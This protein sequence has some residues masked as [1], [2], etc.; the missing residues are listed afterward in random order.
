MQSDV[1]GL[2]RVLDEIG[3]GASMFLNGVSGVP[4]SQYTAEQAASDLARL[5]VLA[6]E[7]ERLATTSS[8]AHL[9]ICPQ[10]GDASSLASPTGNLYTASYSTASAIDVLTEQNIAMMKAD[11]V[12]REGIRRVATGSYDKIDAL[13]KQKKSGPT[14]PPKS[15]PVS[16]APSS[17]MTS[18]QPS[19]S[20]FAAP[21]QQ[22]R[23]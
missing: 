23:M 12:M 19:S 15:G 7:C 18:T 20:P 14:F 9:E 16:S 5:Q 2:W 4:F 22:R 1:E 3:A 11:V 6:T 10:S 21:S 17:S 8:L 13:Q